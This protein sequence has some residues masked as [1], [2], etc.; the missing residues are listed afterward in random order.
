MLFTFTVVCLA[1]D[2]DIALL[3]DHFNCPLS[4]TTTHQYVLLRGRTESS[5]KVIGRAPN[6]YEIDTMLAQDPLQLQ[7]H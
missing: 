3:P 5:P 4:I 6:N 1:Y 2:S 7:G